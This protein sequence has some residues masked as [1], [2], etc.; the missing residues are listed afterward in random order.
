MTSQET[1]CHQ[2]YRYVKFGLMVTGETEEEHLPKFYS[3]R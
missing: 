3:K 2:P 1:T